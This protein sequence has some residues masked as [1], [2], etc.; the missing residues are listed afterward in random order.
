MTS[1]SA[2]AIYNTSYEQRTPYISFAELAGAPTAQDLFNLLPGGSAQGQQEAAVETIAR[3][4]AWVDNYTCGTWGTL[5]ATVEVE[6]AR[7][8]GS[9]R[10][11]LAIHTKYQPIVEVK[12][13]SYSAIPGGLSS[14]NAASI[15]PAG[16]ITIYPQE[17]EVKLQGVVSLGLNAPGGIVSRW[18]YDTSYVYVAGW[19]NTVLTAS[20]A[21]GAMSIQPLV[22]TGMYPGTLLNLYDLPNDE[23]IQISNT[24]VPGASIVPLV[25]PLVYAHATTATVTNL[26]PS[27]KQAAIW[28]TTAF[29][30]QRGSGALIA[31]D[32]GEATRT[33]TGF[34][35]NA[36]SDWE[37]AKLLLNP[38][39]QQY[40]GW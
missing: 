31:A 34:A 25:S 30:K 24:Y 1:T 23:A 19:P 37:Q 28:A 17:F 26:P 3:A 15:T 9:Y 16:N 32:I 38:F 29:L 14:G 4:S 35:Q 39:R 18:E 5:C 12:A 40:V 10:G 6:N 21:A 33:D 7:V 27:V 13:F 36:G 11:T 20:V 8:W 2:Y 22:V